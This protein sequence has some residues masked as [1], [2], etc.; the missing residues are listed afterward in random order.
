MPHEAMSVIH[1]L[2]AQ[3]VE[4]QTKSRRML[5]AAWMAAKSAARES[6]INAE[7]QGFRAALDGAR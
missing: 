6:A 3:R 5:L 1:I 4:Q 2:V 7:S